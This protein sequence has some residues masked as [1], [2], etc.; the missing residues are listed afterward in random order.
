MFS[1][2]GYILPKYNKGLLLVVSGILIF[3]L[4]Y[5]FKYGC[6]VDVESYAEVF[7]LLGGNW[8]PIYINRFDPGFVV[9]NLITSI[10]FDELYSILLV[11]YVLIFAIAAIAFYKFSPYPLF[12]LFLFFCISYVDNPIRQAIAASIFL[13]T[14][15][16]IYQK[17]GIYYFIMVIVATSFHF[18]AL[19]MIPI[20][21]IARIKLAINKYVIIFLCSFIIGQVINFSVIIDSL[22]ML[23]GKLGYVGG[24]ERI[25][26]TLGM[27]LQVVIFSITLYYLYFSQNNQYRIVFNIYFIGLVMYFLFNSVPVVATRGSDFLTIFQVITIPYVIELSKNRYNRIAFS[28]LS[29]L[30]FGYIYSVQVSNSSFYQNINSYILNY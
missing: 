27:M 14:I 10:F 26:L 16:F 3:F 9:L 5:I 20:Y 15:D 11:S 25:G 29:L 6:V 21:F 24:G 30:L 12:S 17:K 19:L 22:F 23:F 2:L 28:L 7:K 1:G 4:H 13:L 18:T 8:N